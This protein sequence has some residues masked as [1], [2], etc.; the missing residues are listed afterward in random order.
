MM[1]FREH[2]VITVT[3]D[4][5]HDIVYTEL[6]PSH[7]YSRSHSTRVSQ[8]EGAGKPSEHDLPDGDGGG[9]MW[10]I[11]SYWRFVQQ[12]G[13]TYLEVEAVSLSRA[14]PTGVGWIIKPYITSVPR[15]SLEDTLSYTRS[16]VLAG[17][18]SSGMG[19]DTGQRTSE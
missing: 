12:D 6:D 7:W 16:G 14:I 9:F 15:K 8:V 18:K 13:G 19:P 4:T 11:D 5:E 3:L 10:R 1:R 2:H 17:S